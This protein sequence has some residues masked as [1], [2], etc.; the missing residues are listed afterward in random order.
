MPS[1]H[2]PSHL[3]CHLPYHL[4]EGESLQA[5]GQSSEEASAAFANRA[6]AFSAALLLIWFAFSA[7]YCMCTMPFKQDTLLYGRSKSD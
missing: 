1:P 2:L 7:I 4:A 6:T 5:I 3:P